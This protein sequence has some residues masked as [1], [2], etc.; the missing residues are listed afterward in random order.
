VNVG[1]HSANLKFCAVRNCGRFWP[2]CNNCVKRL[3]PNFVF[4]ANILPGLYATL[5][6]SA[7]A[8]SE[9]ENS[10]QRFGTIPTMKSMSLRLLY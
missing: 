3:P 4:F 7:T 10:P 2:T 6:I 5:I 1:L 9:L 8:S